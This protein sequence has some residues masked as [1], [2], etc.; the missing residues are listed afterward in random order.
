MEKSRPYFPLFVDLWDKHILVVGGG[1]I[2]AR[3][4]H[5]MASFCGH[6]RVVA[7]EIAGEIEKENVSFEERPFLR[8][9]LEGI[10]MVFAATNAPETDDI[11]YRLC[12]HKEIPINVASDRNKCDFY[13][14]GIVQSGEL[15]AGVT[16]SGNNHKR[17]KELREE[18][19]KKCFSKEGRDAL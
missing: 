10:D 7:P 3:R 12:K 18:I 13:F 4:V 8:E 11:I 15:V 16:A 9:D 19:E 2:A 5:T 14:P 17:A 6:I 1:K